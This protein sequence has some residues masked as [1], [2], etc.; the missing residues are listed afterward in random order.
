MEG[1]KTIA[2][3]IEQHV[4]QEYDYDGGSHGSI[5]TLRT[6]YASFEEAIEAAKLSVADSVC[7]IC[8]GGRTFV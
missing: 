2:H 7:V 8:E 4:E 1:R 3:L 6:E 5:T